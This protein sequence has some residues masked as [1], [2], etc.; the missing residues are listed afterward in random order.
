MINSLNIGV[1][2]W[3][4]PVSEREVVGAPLR[5]KIKPLDGLQYLEV[6]SDSKAD[7]EGNFL[8]TGSAYKLV[9]MYGIVSWENFYDNSGAEI[10]FSK[11]KIK[12]I[13]VTVLME[14]VS[15]ILRA[16]SLNGEQQKNS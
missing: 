15:E 13:P 12:L 3:Y 2:V 14:L 1:P 5:F 16:S 8:L 9:A 10:V 7:D 11:D 4:T 6:S